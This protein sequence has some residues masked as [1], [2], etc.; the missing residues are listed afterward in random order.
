[1][2]WEDCLGEVRLAIEGIFWDATF[3]LTAG[4]LLL[5]V[6][7][8][9]LQL[10]FLAFLLAI[11]ACLLTIRAFLLTIRALLLTVGKRV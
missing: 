4:S 1:M 11:G 5:T 8:P 6:E 10:C 2:I 3:L 9:R 7:L